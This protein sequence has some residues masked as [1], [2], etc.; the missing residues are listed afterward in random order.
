MMT[1]IEIAEKVKKMSADF[2]HPIALVKCGE[3]LVKRAWFFQI[4]KMHIPNLIGV[5]EGD[6]PSENIVEDL[7]DVFGN[8]RLKFNATRSGKSFGKDAS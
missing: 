1:Q 5:Y 3:N 7:S 6:T 4:K 2:R 8:Q